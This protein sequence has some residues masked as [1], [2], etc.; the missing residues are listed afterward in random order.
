MIDD[1]VHKTMELMLDIMAYL[2]ALNLMMM[3]V[4]MDKDYLFILK[5]VRNKS[6]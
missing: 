4:E 6:K 3:V 5:F 2:L 1:I